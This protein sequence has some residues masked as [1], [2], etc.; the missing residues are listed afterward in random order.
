M[1]AVRTPLLFKIKLSVSPFNNNN[2]QQKNQH[3][4][5]HATSST[6]TMNILLTKNYHQVNALKISDLSF[7]KPSNN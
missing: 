3:N 5:Q 1:P 2:N 7:I 4:N 6:F